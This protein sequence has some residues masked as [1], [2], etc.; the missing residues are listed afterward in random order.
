MQQRTIALRIRII[1][2]SAI[3]PLDYKRIKSVKSVANPFG[4]VAVESLL[5]DILVAFVV[6]GEKRLPSR[7]LISH[8]TQSDDRPWMELP[9]A[10]TINDRWLAQQLRPYDVKPKH[11]RFGGTTGRGYALEDFEEIF[12]RYIPKAELERL[13]EQSTDAP[14]QISAADVALD[15]PEAAAA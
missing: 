6:S 3:Y 12:R 1:S 4:L 13:V 11:M 2:E 14:M 5:L 7:V 8:L 10:S 9:K 15:P